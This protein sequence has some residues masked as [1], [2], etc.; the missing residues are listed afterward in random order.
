[1][2]VKPGRGASR[3]FGESPCF[4][5]DERAMATATATATQTDMSAVLSPAVHETAYYVGERKLASVRTVQSVVPIA[6]ADRI[7]AATVDGWTF[8]VA[9]G[10]FSSGSKV[11]YFEIDALLPVEPW[12]E[13][14]RDRGC[15]VRC[16]GVGEGFRIKSTKIRGVVSQGLALPLAAVAGAIHRERVVAPDVALD[17]EYFLENLS[18]GT[19]LT[20]A[21]RVKKFEAF[22]GFAAPMPAGVFPTFLRKTDQE[23]VQN[24]F[25]KLKRGTFVKGHGSAAGAAVAGADAGADAGAADV[26]GEITHGG[27]DSGV[28]SVVSDGG[29]GD[30]LTLSGGS[31][32]T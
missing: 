4:S 7:E 16:E 2:C 18:D 30:G 20:A 15:F 27:G 17:A 6:G 14:L 12:S 24:C 25:K 8:V 28:V 31:L 11:V 21:L 1:M 19:D 26:S 23:R 22:D 9:K 3:E 13:F 29:D 10:A 32:S 5:C